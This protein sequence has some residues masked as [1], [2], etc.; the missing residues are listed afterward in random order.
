M[1]RRLA[2]QPVRARRSFLP[3]AGAR[4]GRRAARRSA[5]AR[6]RGARLTRRRAYRARARIGIV[7]PEH[8]LVVLVGRAQ[9]RSAVSEPGRRIA[10][11]ADVR[12]A[13]PASVR[14]P[15]GERARAPARGA[16]APPGHDRA[17]R[18]GSRRARRLAHR[19]FGAGGCL[20]PRPA[21]QLLDVSPARLLPPAGARRLLAVLRQRVQAGIRHAATSERGGEPAAGAGLDPVSMGAARRRSEGETR[22]GRASR[23]VA[24]PCVARTGEPRPRS[25]GSRG[26]GRRCQRPAATEIV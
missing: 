6:E 4:P 8:H 2:L 5:R 13:G 17:A 12:G 19:Q 22:G 21:A 1:R 3:P 15:V 16:G 23:P 24:R 7:L 20:R 14:H 9:E 11:R 10:V 25:F 18:G 26:G